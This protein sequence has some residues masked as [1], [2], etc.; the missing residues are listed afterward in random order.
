MIRNTKEKKNTIRE[1]TLLFDGKDLLIEEEKI[2][3]GQCSTDIL[4]LDDN[5]IYKMNVARN[6]WIRVIQNL[7][8][9]QLVP[10]REVITDA[11]AKLDTM[12]DLINAL[13]PYKYFENSNFGKGMLLD[14]FEQQPNDLHILFNKNTRDGG[15]IFNFLFLLIAN[16]DSI[17][18]FKQYFG[19]MT[20]IHLEKLKKR[21]AREY[22]VGVY[23]F[24][25]YEST[26]KAIAEHLPKHSIFQLQQQIHVSIE[27]TPMYAPDDSFDYILVERIVFRELESF[28]YM[29]FFRGLMSGHAPRRCHNCGTYF[30]LEAGYNSCYCTNI[31]P[32]ENNVEMKT[33]RDVGAH[34]KEVVKKGNRT[35]EQ[36]EYD[37]VYNRLKTR[38][39]RGHMSEAEYI[40]GMKLAKEY[41]AQQQKGELNESIYFELMKK[42]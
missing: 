18:A 32:D 25:K 2:S 22:A 40:R 41:L 29:D 13:P 5:A 27:Y 10:T 30:L 23:Q 24:F 6:E 35:P 4:N 31:A 28:L 20:D 19:V 39:N 34:K 3:L 8:E 16:I 33:C 7:F 42:F 15:A 38:K 14:L 9:T 37:K 12:L 36:K 1:F 26:Q 21:N 17:F 11:Q